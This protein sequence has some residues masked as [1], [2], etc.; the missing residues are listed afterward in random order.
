MWR[1]KITC[2]ARTRAGHHCC[3][4]HCRR[5]PDNAPRSPWAL[6]GVW[7]DR[8]PLGDGEPCDAVDATNS[9]GREGEPR[10]ARQDGWTLL[11]LWDRSED[12]RPGSHAS[13]AF[14]AD[15]TDIEALQAAREHFPKVIARIE[16]HIDR[17]LEIA[18]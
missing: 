3:A 2:N 17:P 4:P 15:L 6:R 14:N 1:Y 8:Y 9:S 7:G 5:V 16:A 11:H 18:A 10:F 13:F 12:T